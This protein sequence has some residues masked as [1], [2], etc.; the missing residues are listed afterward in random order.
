MNH[1]LMNIDWKLNMTYQNINQIKV[2]YVLKEM[3]TM[4]F[5][6]F[7]VVDIKTDIKQWQLVQKG[8][9]QMESCEGCKKYVDLPF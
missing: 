2:I 4:N 7:L 5:D 3:N 9:Q 8:E 6:E 1:K